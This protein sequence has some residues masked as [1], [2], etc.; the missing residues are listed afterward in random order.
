MKLALR[1]LAFTLSALFAA[2]TNHPVEEQAELPEIV[3]V[4]ACSDYCPGPKEK[5]LRRVYDGITDA[6]KCRELGGSPYTYMGWGTR[7]VCVVR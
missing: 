6:E 5:Y 2:C 3:E 4:F 1:T 7:T